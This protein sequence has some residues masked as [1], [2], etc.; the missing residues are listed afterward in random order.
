MFFYPK[1]KDI[2]FVD[3]EA[4]DKPKRLLQFGAIKLK[5]DGTTEEVNWFSNPKCKISNHVQGIV[6]NNLQK[7]M[8][9]ENNLKIMGKIANFIN[10]CIFIS[11]SN[12]DFN[13]LNS[14]YTKLYKKKLN[15][16]YI[17][18]QWEWKKITLNKD[19]WAL[20]KLANFFKIDIFDDN[21]HDALYDAKIMFE[22]FKKWNTSNDVQ[23]LSSIYKNKLMN[24][25]IIKIKQNKNRNSVTLNNLEL[26][27]GFVF[28]DL[29]FKSVKFNYFNKRERFLVD[30]NVLEIQNNSIKRNWNFN[31]EIDPHKFDRDD[32]EEKIINKLKQYIIS[33]RYKKIVIHDSKHQDLIRLCN[34][35][36]KYI[37]V[38][39]L[40]KVI[41]CNG[42]DNLFQ[43]IN[44]EMYK[45]EQNLFLIKR[46]LVFNHISET[47]DEN[48]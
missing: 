28:I 24:E 47:I 31:Y 32:Y 5:K 8:S 7:I 1:D 41:F 13:F 16:I 10:D 3:I 15:C 27:N 33:I 11:Y 19:V 46:W 37:K 44:D 42:F 17:D 43:D 22:I 2:V 38:F 39:P 23:L 29:T 25:V 18:L 40:N 9:G 34:E 20:K 45:Y 35:C 4:N 21:L 12:F 48:S 26:N 30:L 6:K 14:L 36:S